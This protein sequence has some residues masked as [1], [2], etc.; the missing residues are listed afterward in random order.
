MCKRGK[1]M[2]FVLRYVL[3]SQSVNERS[4][5]VESGLRFSEEKKDTDKNKCKD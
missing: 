3:I 2:F 4:G 5:A 1:G